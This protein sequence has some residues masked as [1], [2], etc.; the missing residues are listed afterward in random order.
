MNENDFAKRK[1]AAAEQLRQMNKN[2]Q[3]NNPIE[4]AAQTQQKTEPLNFLNSINIPFLDSFK[5]DS[6]FALILGLLLLILGEKADK[7]LLFALIYILL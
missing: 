6:D 7:R 5:T 2:S 3:K 4:P 1:F